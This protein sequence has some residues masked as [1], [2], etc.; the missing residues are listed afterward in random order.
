[1]IRVWIRCLVGLYH[2]QNHGALH[3]PWCKLN[4]HSDGQEATHG[5]QRA[6]ERPPK[7]STPPV[8]RDMIDHHFARPPKRNQGAATT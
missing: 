8:G 4:H 1:M 6:S 2:G 3:C 5:R 7:N